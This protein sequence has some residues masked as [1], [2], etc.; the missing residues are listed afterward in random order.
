MAP[1]GDL[2]PEIEPSSAVIRA[3][4][5]WCG[6][7][8]S[9]APLVDRLAAASGIDV[10]DLRVDEE[11]ELVEQYRVRS[12]PTLIGL[13]DGAE[14]GRLV[15]LQSVDAIEAL[16]SAT[17]AEGGP[18]AAREPRS[19]VATRAAAGVVLVAFGLI[20]SAVPLTVVGAALAAW[21]LVGL[22]RG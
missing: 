17:S 10:I 11:P 14:V 22:A 20:L 6:S 4:A 8:R 9:M 2:S 13:H 7:C 19:L 15:G 1:D 5:P 3:W 16:F 21:A 12:V 18:I